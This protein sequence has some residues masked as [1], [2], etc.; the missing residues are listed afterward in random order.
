MRTAALTKVATNQLA[1]RVI[2]QC[3]AACGGLGFFSFNQMIDYQG[4]TQAYSAAGGDNQMILLEAAW[5]MATGVDYQAPLFEPRAGHEASPLDRQSLARL[6]RNREHLLHRELSDDLRTAAAQGIDSFT[7]WNDRADQAQRLAE[8]HA[9][10]ITGD[11]LLAQMGS[12]PGPELLGAVEDLHRLWM[13]EEVARHDGWYL[14]AGLLTIEEARSIPLQI[15]ETCARLLPHALGLTGMLQVPREILR[16]SLAKG[17][18][19]RDL[20]PAHD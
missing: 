10:R 1:E 15:T 11:A 14:T 13:L 8:A 3:R 6:I 9:A 20:G 5:A 17:D 12:Q 19:V 7:A 16:A 18:Y 2:S 4:L